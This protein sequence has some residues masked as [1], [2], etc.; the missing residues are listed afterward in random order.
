MHFYPMIFVDFLFFF[1]VG[2]Q[3]FALEFISILKLTRKAVLADYQLQE[4]VMSAILSPLPMRHTRSTE[5]LARVLTMR[6]PFSSSFILCPV[7]SLKSTSNAHS[8][9]RRQGEVLRDICGAYPQ[10]EHGGLGWKCSLH[11]CL[12]LRHMVRINLPLPISI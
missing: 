11:R 10:V 8:P 9:F 4:I 3:I 1:Q 12:F 7:S 6:F 2:D 5:Y